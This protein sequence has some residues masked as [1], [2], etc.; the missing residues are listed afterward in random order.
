M[1]LPTKTPCFCGAVDY[2]VSPLLIECRI[3]GLVWERVSGGWV[4]DSLLHDEVCARVAAGQAGGVVVV[5]R[6]WLPDAPA[7]FI[8]FDFKLPELKQ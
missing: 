6:R 5:D 4:M 2:R 3:C 8:K 7:E 1:T